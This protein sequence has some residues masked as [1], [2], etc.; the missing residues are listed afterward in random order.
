MLNIRN[1]SIFLVLLFLLSSCGQS[2]QKLQ[3]SEN[4]D[5]KY[6]KAKEFYNKEQYDKAIPLFEELITLRK[7]TQSIDEVYYLFAMSHY[8]NGNFLVAAFHFKNINDSYPSS[9]YAE[10]C[11]YMVG[12]SNAELSPD[13][14]LDQTYTEKAIEAF[15]LFVNRYPNSQFLEK[16]NQ[17]ITALRRKLEMKALNA[18]ELYFKTGHYKAAATA[19][20]N[21]L[22]QFPDTKDAEKVNFFIIKSYYEY[23]ANSVAEKQVER[24]NQAIKAYENFSAKYKSSGYA[25]DAEE[26][27][28]NAKTNIDKLDPNKTSSSNN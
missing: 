8:K 25:K 16:S 3:K 26:L 9:P 18:A 15:Q 28:L 17:Q 14:P 1:I 19:F 21:V 23:A 12:V 4:L 5:L 2:L 6:T 13:I 7:G 11:L 24:Y 10:E 20:S 27:Y 22:K